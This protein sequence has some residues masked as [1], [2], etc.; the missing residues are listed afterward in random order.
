[1]LAGMIAG[2]TGITPMYQVAN[3][4]LKDPTDQTEL[5]LIFANVSADDILIQEE[6]DAVAKQYPRFKVLPSLVWQSREVHLCN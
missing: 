2:G 1:M 5:R 6:L 4:I 3:A